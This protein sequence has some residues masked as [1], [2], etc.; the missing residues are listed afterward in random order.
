MMWKNIARSELE[1]VSERSQQWRLGYF[2]KSKGNIVSFRCKFFSEERR[3][4]AEG[5]GGK[6]SERIQQWRMRSFW[7]VK[8]FGGARAAGSSGGKWCARG[9]SAA[10]TKSN[11]Q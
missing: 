6:S 2:C 11:L 8:H 1:S 5:K 9:A 10:S 3:Q 4:R 7:F